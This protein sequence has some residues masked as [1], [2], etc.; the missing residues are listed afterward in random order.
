V[1]IPQKVPAMAARTFSSL[2][3]RA[4]LGCL[5]LALGLA[6]AA[7]PGFAGDV[8]GRVV[9]P[10]PPVKAGFSAPGL[11]PGLGAE[12]GARPDHSGP[13]LVYVAEASAPLPH[14]ETSGAHLSLTGAKTAPPLIALA[15][16]SVLVIENAD[17]RAHRIVAQSDREPRDLGLLAPGQTC[18]LVVRETGVIPLVCALHKEAVAEIVVLA[19]AAFTFADANGGFRLSGLPPGLAT[20]VAYSP[21]FGEV[22]R[23]VTVPDT[24]EVEVGFNF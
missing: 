3:G 8:S 4:A 17:K 9:L 20:V 14:A 1:G 7:A 13:V 21:R 23:E 6:F 18:K 24:G 11:L 19:H 22:S 2:L 5:A 15:L 16:S 10:A 12:T